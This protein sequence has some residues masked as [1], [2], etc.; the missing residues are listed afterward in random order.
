MSKENMLPPD[1]ATWAGI[2]QLDQ[3]KP[4]TCSPYSVPKTPGTGFGTVSRVLKSRLFLGFFS[5][6]VILSL[7]SFLLIEGVFFFDSSKEERQLSPS[8]NI[9][10]MSSHGGAV[11]YHANQAIAVPP[12][13]Q[14]EMAD[15]VPSETPLAADKVSPSQK[16][17]EAVKPARPSAMINSTVAP[18]KTTGITAAEK[19]TLDAAA[20]KAKEMAPDSSKP[21]IRVRKV[22]SN[23]IAPAAIIKEEIIHE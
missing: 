20:S 13:P 6:G 23:E 2:L 10:P 8:F 7:F 21:S 22:T 1:A 19:A 9:Q 4:V 18:L 16:D 17:I 5:F 11:S 15:V 3:F 12:P 14:F